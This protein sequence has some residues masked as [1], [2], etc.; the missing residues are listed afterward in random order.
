MAT[1]K[2]VNSKKNHGQNGTIRNLKGSL[3]NQKFFFF[4]FWHCNQNCVSTHTPY[5][6]APR[7]RKTFN[8]IKGRINKSKLKHLSVFT[9]WTFLH[10]ATPPLRPLFL[11]SY[12]YLY[13]WVFNPFCFL[14]SSKVPPSF[15]YTLIRFLYT[16]YKSI[17]CSCLLK[18]RPHFH[19]LSPDLKCLATVL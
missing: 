6:Y 7:Q 19:F 12:L 3:R 2:L 17:L 8:A 5:V 15:S 16:A 18:E 9:S 10:M 13:L 11:Y 1:K 4:F 14:M